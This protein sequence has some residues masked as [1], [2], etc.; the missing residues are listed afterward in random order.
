MG[1]SGPSQLALALLS[2]HMMSDLMA[3]KFYQDFKSLVIEKLDTDRWRL[4][5][6]DVQRFMED[7]KSHRTSLIDELL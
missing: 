3:L 1:V 6:S 4:T 2:D 5:S 7:I